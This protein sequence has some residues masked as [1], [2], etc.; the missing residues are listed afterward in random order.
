[1]SSVAAVALANV[2]VDPE[3]NAVVEP[4]LS[5]LALTV[6]RPVYVLAPEGMMVPGP[7]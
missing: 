2:T 3:L 7:T 5:T 4:A 6:V 1:M